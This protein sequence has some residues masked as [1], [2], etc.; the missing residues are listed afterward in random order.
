MAGALII[1]VI[2]LTGLV[3]T[4]AAWGHNNRLAGYRQLRRDHARLR[5]RNEHTTAVLGMVRRHAQ[6]ADQSGLP[7]PAERSST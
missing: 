6:V 1:G 5:D 4:L 7:S 3:V 2:I